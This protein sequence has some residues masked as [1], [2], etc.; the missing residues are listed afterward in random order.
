M[1]SALPLPVLV[2]FEAFPITRGDCGVGLLD[3]VEES[4]TKS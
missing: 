3:R 4:V 2:S 1:V